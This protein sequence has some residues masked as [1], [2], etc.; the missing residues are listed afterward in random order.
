MSDSKNGLIRQFALMLGAAIIGGVLVLFFLKQ[1]DDN[2]SQDDDI[3]KEETSVLN[4]T[5]QC[6]ALAADPED[7]HRTVAGVYLDEFTHGR[8]SPH[9]ALQACE[10]ALETASEEDK[11][12]I[13]Y[14]LSRLS[15][16]LDRTAQA[17][18]YL[19]SSQLADYPAADYTV[20]MIFYERGKLNGSIEYEDIIRTLRF[21][22]ER[23]HPKAA[24][25]MQRLYE[26]EFP[27]SGYQLPGLM[28]AIYDGNQEAIP[29]DLFTRSVNLAIYQHL[30]DY[31]K[32]FEATVINILTDAEVDNYSLPLQVNSMMNGIAGFFEM[33]E[34]A[35]TSVDNFNRDA[36]LGKMIR[37]LNSANADWENS[38]A[39]MHTL[40]YRDAGLLVQNHNCSGPQSNRFINNLGA[41][42]EAR[43]GENTIKANQNQIEALYKKPEFVIPKPV[44]QPPS[45]ATTP[46]N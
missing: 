3:E 10:R 42:F 6:D 36:D 17:D 4:A 37:D 43:Q 33:L 41:L 27:L 44:V 46:N 35:S 39:Y 21:A 13:N 22:A 25:E 30:K 24:S 45:Y 1:G 12:R 16:Y 7:P 18:R 38:M 8:R 31:C 19:R 5:Q 26:E 2:F 29:D 23:G 28:R 20:A 15:R 11:P 32:Q 34:K 14:Q 40:G 9:D